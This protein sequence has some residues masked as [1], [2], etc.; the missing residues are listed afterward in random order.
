MK[1]EGMKRE[2]RGNFP[3]K[4]FSEG[5]GLEAR[6]FSEKIFLGSENTKFCATLVAPRAARPGG[7]PLPT[8]KTANLPQN[9]ATQACETVQKVQVYTPHN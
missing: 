9:K 4:K 5:M 3:E 2:E 8:R 6:D 7:V 1:E